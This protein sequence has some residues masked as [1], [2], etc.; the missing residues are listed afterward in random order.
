MALCSTHSVTVRINSF[1]GSCSNNYTT[2]EVG[3]CSVA[4]DAVVS[5]CVCPNISAIHFEMVGAVDCIV[6]RVSLN[7]TAIDIYAVLAFDGFACRV[8]GCLCAV[9]RNMTAVDY[10]VAYSLNAFWQTFPVI[11]R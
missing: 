7:K 9:R 3:V 2:I 5:A 8:A 11:G 6:V 4:V 10:N 1:F